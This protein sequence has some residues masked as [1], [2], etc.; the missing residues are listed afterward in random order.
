MKCSIDEFA[1]NGIRLLSR[2]DLEI[3]IYMTGDIWITPEVKRFKN[4]I[5]EKMEGKNAE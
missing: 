5:M 3:L 2:T 4:G 1:S